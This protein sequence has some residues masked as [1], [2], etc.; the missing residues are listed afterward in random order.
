MPFLRLVTCFRTQNVQLLAI[1]ACGD[2]V[3]WKSRTVSAL[4][5]SSCHSVLT[6]GVC[7]HMAATS[8]TMLRL[9][10][11]LATKLLIFLFFFISVLPICLGPAASC[12]VSKPNKEDLSADTTNMNVCGDDVHDRAPVRQGHVSVSL[13]TLFAVA[14][15]P[16]ASQLCL[17]SALTHG[18]F[19]SSLC[20]CLCLCVTPSLL[21]M[22]HAL[23]CK[24]RPTGNAHSV[25]SLKLAAAVPCRPCCD[26]TSSD[27]DEHNT[28]NNFLLLF[29][30][31]GITP[32]LPEGPK[33]D[34]LHTALGCRFALD[35]FH[36]F[37]ATSLYT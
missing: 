15:E 18:R 4:G 32:T 33:V 11:N 8:L 29:T 7:I 23:G 34:V 31:V 12:V 27:D 10:W 16:F 22:H 25:F 5:S 19:A 17:L 30:D 2:L 24:Y 36:D 26:F 21:S 3:H 35:F 6:S 37:V 1:H 9:A 14:R 20:P 28:D 13:F